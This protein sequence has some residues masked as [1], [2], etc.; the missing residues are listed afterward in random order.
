M[1]EG[2]RCVGGVGGIGQG[3]AT[4]QL[5]FA[6]ALRTGFGP[7]LFW[8][9]ELAISV[10]LWHALSEQRPNDEAHHNSGPEADIDVVEVALPAGPGWIH[11]HCSMPPSPA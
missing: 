8:W 3:T 10:A 9:G 7:F 6:G 2:D 5:G 11:S 1:N 4:L